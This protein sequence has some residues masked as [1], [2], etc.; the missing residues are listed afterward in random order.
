MTWVFLMNTYSQK[1]P[2]HALKRKQ[3][4]ITSCSALRNHSRLTCLELATEHPVLRPPG[5]GVQALPWPLGKS[6]GHHWG[7]LL[8]YQWQAALLT[9]RK[10]QS[11]AFQQRKNKEYF[12]HGTKSFIKKK[13]K[14][15]NTTIVEKSKLNVLFKKSGKYFAG[16][17]I[18]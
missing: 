4:L 18:L 6:Q 12:P 10:M 9:W 16:K 13:K 3:S 15:R 11:K 14:K 17:F 2:V 8:S 5:S 1:I 7:W